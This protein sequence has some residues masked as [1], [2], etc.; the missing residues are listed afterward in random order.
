MIHLKDWKPTK[1]SD[2]FFLSSDIV[3]KYK[4]NLYEEKELVPTLVKLSEDWNVPYNKVIDF[5]IDN[6]LYTELFSYTTNRFGKLVAERGIY[7]KNWVRHYGGGDYVTTFY[8]V[9][10]CEN[11]YFSLQIPKIV[12]WII[13]EYYP[14][15]AIFEDATPYEGIEFD[16]K[17]RLDDFER[18]YWEK[19]LTLGDVINIFKNP[20]MV[21][22]QLRYKLYGNCDLI[23]LPITIQN[24]HGHKYDISLYIPREAI[25]KKD[26][27]FVENQRL[28]S[29]I[30]PN[31]NAEL[32]KDK[33]NW[34]DGKQKDNPYWDYEIVKN[35]KAMWDKVL[36]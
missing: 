7:T 32:G 22:K 2:S 21:K 16:E 31:A 19:H 35:I 3:E 24:L 28:Y 27:S 23:F 33:N 11:Q 9:Y 1:S 10:V 30:K 12:E 29:I 17:M 34:F 14:F 25:V 6:K 8:D 20:N 15:C 18:K 36:K 13:T 4:I 5:V 26:W